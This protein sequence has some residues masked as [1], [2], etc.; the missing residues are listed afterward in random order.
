[1]RVRVCEC[2]HR[3]AHNNILLVKMVA[4]LWTQLSDSIQR[5]EENHGGVTHDRQVSSLI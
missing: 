3:Y 1:M 5:M 2:E 4:I